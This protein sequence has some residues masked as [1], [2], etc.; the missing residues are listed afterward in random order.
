MI[1]LNNSRYV[2]ILGVNL[3]EKGKVVYIDTNAQIEMELRTR[4]VLLSALD[5]SIYL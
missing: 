3:I 2:K 4:I 1:E 5:I